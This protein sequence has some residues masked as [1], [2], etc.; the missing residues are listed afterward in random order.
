MLMKMCGQLT[1]T[2]VIGSLEELAPLEGLL[3]GGSVED[4]SKIAKANIKKSR[5]ELRTIPAR[6]DELYRQI[7]KVD[8]DK[9]ALTDKTKELQKNRDR[10]EIFIKDL[11]QQPSLDFTTPSAELASTNNRIKDLELSISGCTSKIG[12]IN[13]QLQELKGEYIELGNSKPGICPTCGQTMPYEKFKETRDKRGRAIAEEVNSLKSVRQKQENLMNSWKE[14]LQVLQEQAAELQ[15]KVD[16]TKGQEPKIDA[17]Q[18]KL[19]AAYRQRDEL[20]NS[21]NEVQDKIRIIEQQE[22]IKKRIN[23]L[24]ERETV[25]NKLIADNERQLYLTEIFARQKVKLIEQNI[26][27]KFNFVKFKMFKENLNGSIEE[28]CEALIDNVP[29]NEGLNRGAK[30]KASLDIISTLSE[31]YGVRLP[32]FID[33][34]ESYTSNSIIEIDNQVIRLVAVEGVKMLAVN[35]RRSEGKAMRA[36]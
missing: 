19:N 16:A 2:D 25:V 32:L 14:E 31:Y 15:K 23:E 3:G 8:G 36:A 29:Y 7:V 12:H 6:I 5:E 13:K 30:M 27:S 17:K 10:I 18:E 35:V 22:Q 9:A 1:D 28:C 20:T 24:K 4:F 26:N 21:I 33:D 11:Q 34:A